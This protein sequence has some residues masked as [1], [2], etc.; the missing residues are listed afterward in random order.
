MRTTFDAVAE[1]YDRV[2]PSYPGEVFDDLVELARLSP[3]ARLLEIGCGTGQVTRPLAQRGFTVVAVELGER[4]AALTRRR[5]VDFP[6]VEVLVGP[7]EEWE[8]AGVADFD[9]VVS[10]AAFHWIDPEVR[11]AKAARLLKPDGALAVF[12][13][14]DTLSDHGDPFFVAVQEDYAAVVPEWEATAPL[15]PER[16]ADRVTVFLD[17]SGYFAPAQARRYVWSVTYAAHDYV[18]F[19]GTQSSFRVLDEARRKR[20]FDRIEHRITAE[21][22]GSVRKEFF[23]ILA[24][25]RP[26]R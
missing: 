10:F 24:V 5:L 18:T 20:L 19:L 17:A 23:G 1:D 11:Y 3:G 2:R 6:T 25:A 9:A 14:E 12:D 22:G 4:L 21:H 13:W 26:A 16:V 8:P 15:P 7:F